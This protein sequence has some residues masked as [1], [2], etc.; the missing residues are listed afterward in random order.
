MM[1]ERNT[2]HVFGLAGPQKLA[3]EM[4]TD[5]Q[6]TRDAALTALGCG[7]TTTAGSSTI[8]L[9]SKGVSFGSMVITHASGSTT[10]TQALKPP[11]AGGA[12]SVAADLIVR[13]FHRPR[14]RPT[15]RR[16]RRR[17]RPW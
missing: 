14:L 5:L 12:N 10:C 6:A 15:S 1:I 13:P 16:R 11:I 2:P 17:R 4:T 7:K 9:A 3:E 8:T